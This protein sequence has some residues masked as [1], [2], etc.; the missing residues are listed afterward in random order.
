MVEAASSNTCAMAS[1]ASVALTPLR[2]A[3][4]MYYSNNIQNILIFLHN[5]M[6]QLLH[7]DIDPEHNVLHQYYVQNFIKPFLEII[8]I[9]TSEN[10]S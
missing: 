8:R 9:F 3:S 10:L 5:H 4:D 1:T 2:Q 7:T 6:S